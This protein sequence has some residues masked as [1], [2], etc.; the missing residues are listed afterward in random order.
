MPSHTSLTTTQPAGLLSVYPVWRPL[1]LKVQP[2]QT[3]GLHLYRSSMV[4]QP[5]PSLCLDR[6]NTSPNLH[7]T[8]SWEF[9]GGVCSLVGFISLCCSIAILREEAWSDAYHSSGDGEQLV[10]ILAI[11]NNIPYQ[12]AG[13]VHPAQV[14]AISLPSLEKGCPALG[15]DSVNRKLVWH[16]N[17]SICWGY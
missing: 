6:P 8:E 7:V 17:P 16:H 13:S 15:Y 9:L 11:V 3:A 5:H 4:D 1:F 2:N 14:I 12:T 10:V